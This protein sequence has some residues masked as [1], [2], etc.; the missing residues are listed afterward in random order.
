MLSLTGFS[1]LKMKGD[2]E[3]VRDINDE[4]ATAPKRLSGH[5]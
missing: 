3:Y 2:V 5:D 4:N 1:E